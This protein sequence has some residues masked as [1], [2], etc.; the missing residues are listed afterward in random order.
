MNQL[1]LGDLSFIEGGHLLVKR[2]MGKINVGKEIVIC[3]QDPDLEVHLEAWAR[4]EGHQI[5]IST[6][7]NRFKLYRGDAEL[8]RWQGAKQTGDPDPF[9]PEIYARSPFMPCTTPT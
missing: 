6:E 5:K 8:K 4:I 7:S 3:G 9:K 2:A 1:D